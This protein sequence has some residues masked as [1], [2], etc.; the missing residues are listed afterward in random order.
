MRPF[1]IFRYFVRAGCSMSRSPGGSRSLRP[2]AAGGARRARRGGLR[3][4][5]AAH[6]PHL[7]ADLAVGGL[8]LGEPVVDVRAQ[9]VERHAALAVPLVA[10]HL[11]AAEA[12]RAGDAD[13]LRAE[14]E[15]GLDRLL[16]RAAEGDA[17]LELGRDV[18]GDELR[19]GLGLTDLDDVQVDLVLREGLE[20]LL[21]GLDAR[22]ALADDDAR[23][24]RVDVDLDLVGRPLDLD[25]GDAG[26]AELL[27]HELAEADVLVEPLRVVPLLVPLRIPGPDDAEPEPDRMD[28]L[29]HASLSSFPWV[30]AA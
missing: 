17:A 5:L 30:P 21:D 23:A 15:G 4:D 2:G 20:V 13:A 7:H 12:A 10:R 3:Q 9:R 25:A 29:S 1:I 24:R 18:L 14:L 26:L 28:F 16:H 8:R 27:L 11:G 22:A 6:D 19:V